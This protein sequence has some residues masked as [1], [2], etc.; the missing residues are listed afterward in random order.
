L[1]VWYIST[2]CPGGWHREGRTHIFFHMK[3][4]C[5]CRL[6]TSFNRGRGSGYGKRLS[7]CC[8]KPFLLLGQRRATCTPALDKIGNCSAPRAPQP[9]QELLSI[10]TQQTS[11][12]AM[13]ASEPYQKIIARPFLGMTRTPGRGTCSGQLA[14][15]F[16][17]KSLMADSDFRGHGMCSSKAQELADEMVAAPQVLILPDEL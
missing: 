15:S 10:T 3:Q 9:H 13:P 4:S 12:K 7:L 6:P 16:S 5:D 11:G 1:A 2:P 17:V 8:P 14:C